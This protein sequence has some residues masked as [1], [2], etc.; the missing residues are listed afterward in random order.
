MRCDLIANGI[1]DAVNEVGVTIPVVVR[2]EGNNAPLG[3]E[4]LANS[5]LNILAANS[6]TDAAKLVVTA[7]AEGK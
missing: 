5:G 4:I 3:R 1:I 7:A 6:L 2:L